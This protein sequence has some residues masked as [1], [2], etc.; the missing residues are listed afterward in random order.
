MIRRLLVLAGLL[1]TPAMV[2]ARGEP[3]AYSLPN[4]LRVRLVPGGEKDHVGLLLGVRAGFLDEP[5]GVPH[6]AHVTE[7]LATYAPR[8]AEETQAVARWAPQN[9]ANGET[10]ADFMYF[11]LYPSTAELPLA[12]RVQAGRLTATDFPAEVLTREVPRTLAEIDTV[13]KSAFGGTF[14]FALAPFVQLALH[15]RPD[16]A[17]IRARTRAITLDQ[18]RDF[19]RRTFQPDR[20]ELIVLGDFDPAAARKEIEQRF[21]KIPRP[22]QAP[23]ARPA[24]RP[25]DH[26]AAWDVS[27]R[28]LLIA[29]P[30]P[31]PDHADHPALSLAA[32]ALQT[33]L[34]QDSELRKL[35]KLPLV[36]NDQ[37]GVFLVNLQLQQDTDAATVKAKLLERVATLARPDGLSDANLAQARFFFRQLTQPPD[38][39]KMPLPPRMTKTMALLNIELQRLRWEIVCGDL[40]AYARRLEGVKAEAVR[41]V[42]A[43]HLTADKACV[44]TLEPR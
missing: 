24:L 38:L 10:L 5:A 30:V 28:H 14:K 34:F 16:A 23:P 25:G 6:V 18:A 27:T 7:H 20:A 4:G 26:K 3:Q 42:A 8:G 31:T 41:A 43:R 35:V 40:D 21:G 17:P 15:N 36:S 29:W 13:E 19:H 11:D 22:E 39:E 37:E 1:S 9:R 12:L 33:R 44:V 32:L 2:L